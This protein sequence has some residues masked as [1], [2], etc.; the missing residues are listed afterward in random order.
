MSGV[1]ICLSIG[2]RAETAHEKHAR[3]AKEEGD[4]QEEAPKHYKEIKMIMIN[5]MSMNKYQQKFLPLKGF[6]F[7]NI[8][9]FITDNKSFWLLEL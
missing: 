2:Q 1:S 3:P 6:C 4:Q 5:K 7:F 9:R 8:T